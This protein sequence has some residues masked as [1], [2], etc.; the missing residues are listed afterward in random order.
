MDW[1][2]RNSKKDK[3][4]EQI[5]IMDLCTQL[6]NSQ[7]LPVIRILKGHGYQTMSINTSID[8]V[9]GFAM[10]FHVHKKMG[11]AIVAPRRRRPLE[12]DA[13]TTMDDLSGF[14]AAQNLN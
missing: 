5:P 14:M 3:D 1:Y 10:S 11:P 4:G 13:T 12:S 2:R 8:S 9:R 7:N 6:Q